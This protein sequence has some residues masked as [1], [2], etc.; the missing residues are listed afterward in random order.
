MKAASKNLDCWLV[1]PV[2]LELGMKYLHAKDR[3]PHRCSKRL[4]LHPWRLDSESATACQRWGL[5]A[6]SAILFVGVCAALSIV[7]CSHR[8]VPPEDHVAWPVI[9]PWNPDSY[10][11]FRAENLALM[12]LIYSDEYIE[13][14]F[15][16]DLENGAAPVQH[17]IDLEALRSVANKI[18]SNGEDSR[19]ILNAAR[20]YLK[21]TTI[22]RAR[23]GIWPTV[24][25]TLESGLADC[26]GRSLLLLSLLLAASQEA[27]AAIGNGHV[28]VVVRVNGR[29]ETVETDPD[30]ERGKIYAIPGF[31]DR[32]LYKVYADRTLK[33]RRRQ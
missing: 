19:Q 2:N 14:P 5:A 15:T 16:V 33:R 9:D 8:S 10:R 17:L 25:D 11:A 18:S 6:W 4:R 1:T 20:Q 28:W 29:W 24:P 3:L 7:G 31:Y 12:D 13:Y 22:Y 23:P 27:Y 32:P 30:P 26:K 21:T